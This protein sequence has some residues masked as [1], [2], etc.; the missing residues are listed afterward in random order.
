MHY[1]NTPNYINGGQKENE[2]TTF[3]LQ[4]VFW[5]HKKDF[6]QKTT[7]NSKKDAIFARF[8]RKKS[9]RDTINAKQP[10]L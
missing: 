7:N 10:K 6:F 4:Y 8:F 2:N 9:L 3:L 1:E 5:G